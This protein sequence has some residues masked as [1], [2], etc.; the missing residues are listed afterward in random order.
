MNDASQN[1]IVNILKTDWNFELKF[2]GN[3]LYM[4]CF[5][6]S[7]VIKQYFQYLFSRENPDVQPNWVPVSEM[8]SSQYTNSKLL[9]TY[10]T[11]SKRLLIQHFISIS[12]V[13]STHVTC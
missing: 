13:P 10:I 8:G 2:G 12:F 3:F 5:K 7:R 1:I 9:L 11:V 6:L 4:I